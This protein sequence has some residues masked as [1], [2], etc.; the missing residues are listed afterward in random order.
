MKKVACLVIIFTI[1]QLIVI[2]IITNYFS[3]FTPMCLAAEKITPYKPQV[4]YSDSEEKSEISPPEKRRIWPWVVGGLVLVG[5]A[6]GAGGSSDGDG[7]ESDRG[8]GGGGGDNVDV[9]VSW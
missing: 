5:I 4:R 9:D 1:Y 8:G 6:L 3:Y 2:P 7:G